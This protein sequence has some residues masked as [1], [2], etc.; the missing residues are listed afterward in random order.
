MV[1]ADLY[2]R[3]TDDKLFRCGPNRLRYGLDGYGRGGNARR[4]AGRDTL[5]IR[6]EMTYLSFDDFPFK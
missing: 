6:L 5:T 2:P 4:D 1:T 3:M